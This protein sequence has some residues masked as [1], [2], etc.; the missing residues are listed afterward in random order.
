MSRKVTL[1]S[2]LM[3]RELFIKKNLNLH[4]YSI[5]KFEKSNNYN[6]IY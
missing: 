5:K 3:S 4:N 2:M 1:A 6:I